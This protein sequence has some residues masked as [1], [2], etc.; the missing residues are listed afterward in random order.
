MSKYLIIFCLFFCY[1]HAYFDETEEARIMNA[2][3]AQDEL[4]RW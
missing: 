2:D 4:N 3:K 1:W